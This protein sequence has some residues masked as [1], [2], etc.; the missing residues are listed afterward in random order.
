VTAGR[1]STRE[2]RAALCA[3]GLR[4]TV[5]IHLAFWPTPSFAQAMRDGQA[6]ISQIVIKLDILKFEKNYRTVL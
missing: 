5:I 4:D 1:A 2:G 3:R 6:A